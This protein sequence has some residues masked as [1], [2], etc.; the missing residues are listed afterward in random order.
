MLG[1][2]FRWSNFHLILAASAIS[3]GC[4]GTQ[5]SDTTMPPTALTV[6]PR[7]ASLVT[8]TQK[9]QFSV[10]GN[11]GQTH[12]AVTWAVDGVVGG[13]SSVG[14]ISPSG[15]YSPPSTAGT[16]VVTATSTSNASVTAAA[17]VA[18]TDLA[19]ITTYHYDLARDGVNASE[20][21]LTPASVNKSTFGKLFACPIDGA[22]YTEPLWIPGLT[23]NGSTHN[24]V[25]VATQ[26][27]S[28][29]AFDGDGSPCQQLWHVNLLD[30]AHGGTGGETPVNWS[31]VGSG[32]KDIYPEIG[33]VGT[34]VID[35]ITSTL[36][37]VT[38]SETSSPVFYQRLHAIDLATGTEKFN[39]PVNISATVP[40]TGDGSVGG[41]LSF[42]P[43]NENQRSALALVN[44]VVYI[45][46][47]SHE[48]T[49]PYHG[50]ML[51]Y[52]ASNVQQQVSIFNANPDGGLSGIW[53][54]GAAPA[55]DTSGNLYLATGNGTFDADQTT[56]PTDDY[57]ETLLKL[58]TSGGLSILDYFTPDDQAF[59]TQEDYDLGSGGVVLLP[60]Q[61]QG[62]VVHLL[63][64]G[65]KEG[66]LYLI[67]R[68]NLG[69]YLPSG[70]SQIVQSFPAENGLF[71]TPAFW[72]DTVYI[73]G[74]TQSGSD[75]FRMF[76]FNPATGRFDA[77][78]SSISSNSFPFPGATPVIS[79]SG[80]SNGIV[81]IVDNS[82]YGV[83]S[84]CGDTAMPAVVYA[85]DP[86]NLGNEFW[87]SSQADGSRDQAGPAVKFSVPTVANGKVYLGTRTEL[88]VYGLLP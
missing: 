37:V 20:Y 81:W 58:G 11:N 29:Y 17:S 80:S 1:R 63:L 6:Q 53:M 43:Q 66:T 85:Y 38:K 36:Y 14:T 4:A 61:N 3:F 23:I 49:S 48:D 13:N 32:Y 56:G 18:V 19:G 65:G 71:G 64:V 9:Q 75:H 70:N 59:L 87:D 51:G 78:P 40:G 30:S 5:P 82:C 62:P 2:L 57:G 76:K 44:G 35:P 73:T 16:H 88:D 22:D 39:A 10:T 33:V 79:A 12:P 21:G 67:D 45:C 74:A 42:N 25:F 28:L 15:L 50:W 54:S 47:A 86:T 55:A 34:P 7:V 77:S 31:D 26:H 84:P 60:D 24:V 72:Q 46:W 68:D 69:H 27:D 52:N 8:L 41:Q 83:P